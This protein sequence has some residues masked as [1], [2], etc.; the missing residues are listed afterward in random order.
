MKET[1]TNTKRNKEGQ[2]RNP[3]NKSMKI[4][5]RATDHPIESKCIA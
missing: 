5:P 3:P 2:E 1:V 4:N